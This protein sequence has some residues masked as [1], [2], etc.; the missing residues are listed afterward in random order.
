MDK[1]NIA[2]TVAVAVF[3]TAGAAA[4]AAPDAD[5]TAR[6]RAGEAVV[7]FEMYWPQR[8]AADVA[9][10]TGALAELITGSKVHTDDVRDALSRH[11]AG[12]RLSQDSLGGAPG[13][14]FTYLPQFDE[15]RLSNLEALAA[16]DPKSDIGEAQ[17]I[18]Q[19]RTA[20]KQMMKAGIV[21]AQ[22]YAS[23]VPQVG[24]RK[25]AGGTVDGV[26]DF[27]HVVEYRVT[28]R[29]SLNGIELANAGARIG[30][31]ANGGVSSLRVG[32]VDVA[33]EKHGVTSLPSRGGQVLARNVSA[34]SIR[35]QFNAR[36]PDAAETRIA[37]EKLM[38]V[39]PDDTPR[40]VIAPTQVFSYALAFPAENGQDV[41]SR[42]HIVG[43]DVTN[44][45]APMIDYTAAKRVAS[46]EP[47]R[48][49]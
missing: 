23:A 45:T 1:T 13:V 24:Y 6:I 47:V 5:S 39:M 16:A 19:A 41:V 7:A 3:L 43:F 40:A 11:Q 17:A 33:R 42:R 29:P 2:K 26:T 31:H 9:E 14:A 8:T 12:Q 37:F 21:D 48:Q 49:Q 22:D 27:N 36:Q 46:D 25:V 10:R 18:A 44:A 28:F 38:Y 34:R 32:G 20:L 35:E 4:L 15:I 30:V